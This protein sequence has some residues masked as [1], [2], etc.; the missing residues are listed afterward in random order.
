MALLSGA[1]WAQGPHEVHLSVSGPAVGYVYAGAYGSPYNWG[2]DLYSMYEPGERVDAGPV[3]SVGYTYALR[4]WLRPGVEASMSLLWADRSRPLAWGKDEVTQACQRYYT[5]MPL[6]HF[7]ML[8][9]AH[10]KFYGKLAAGGQL[11]VG[12]FEK[13]TLRP[14]WQI[15]PAGIQWGGEKIF[16]LAEMG[17]GNVY[18][19]RIGMGIRW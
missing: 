18:L 6:V 15:V 7:V 14:A 1:V 3:L 2:S 11:S 16:G 17:Y 8:D 4:H 12:D 10:F 9:S 13:T 19:F 5:V